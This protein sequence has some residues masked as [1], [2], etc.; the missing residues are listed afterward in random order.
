MPEIVNRD[1][2][3][4]TVIFLAKVTVE[5]EFMVSFLKVLDAADPLMVWLTPEKIVVVLFAFA[6]Y[7][8]LLV[9][10]PVSDMV[11]PPCVRVAL[12]LITTAPNT[13]RFL[14][15]VN[16]VAFEPPPNVKLLQA[17]ELFIAG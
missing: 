12:L 3:P 15:T 4:D 9:Q 8:P 2:V 10:L 11:A 17:D 7:V 13:E 6:L 1:C 16:V 5:P 14:L